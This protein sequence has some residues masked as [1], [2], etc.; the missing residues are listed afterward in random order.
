MLSGMAERRNIDYNPRFY[1]FYIE[2]EKA[3]VKESK[4]WWTMKRKKLSEVL[5]VEEITRE[6]NRRICIVSGVG[7]GKNY[8]VENELVKYGNILYISSRRA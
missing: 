4:G 6:E 3:W 1:L 2:I 8:F 7:S 5:K